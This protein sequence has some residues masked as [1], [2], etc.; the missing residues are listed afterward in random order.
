MLK[1]ANEQIETNSKKLEQRWKEYIAIL[2][3]RVISIQ[4]TLEYFPYLQ[5]SL[6][7]EDG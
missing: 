7:L 2:Y 6:V 1:D 4:D 3:I 5:E